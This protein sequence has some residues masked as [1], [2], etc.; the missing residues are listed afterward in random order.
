MAGGL[1]PAG[2]AWDRL[3][4]SPQPSSG[5][6]ALGNMSMARQKGWWTPKSAL[7]V[8]ISSLCSRCLNALGMLFLASQPST[9]RRSAFP[10]GDSGGEGIAGL[11]ELGFERGGHLEMLRK[12][13]Q[14][15]GR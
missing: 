9:Q 4:A 8:R 11:Q 15:E 10:S 1:H 6:W 7:S 13:E 5:A 3:A 14:P 2:V 12:E